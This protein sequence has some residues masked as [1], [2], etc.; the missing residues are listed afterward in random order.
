MPDCTALMMMVSSHS[1]RALK[2]KFCIIAHMFKMNHI[3]FRKRVIAQQHFETL[4]KN[5][6]VA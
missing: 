6:H 4:C 2:M 3:F 5:G 1:Y